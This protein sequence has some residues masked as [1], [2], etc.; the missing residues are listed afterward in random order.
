MGDWL[1]VNA[2]GRP[3]RNP[4]IQTST[5]AYFYYASLLGKIAEI[6]DRNEDSKKYNLLAKKIK[7]AFNE[8]FLNEEGRY[9]E[10]SQTV[11]IMPFYLGLAPEEKQELILKRLL[12]YIEQRQG[13]LSS[14][15]V[16]Y[17][18]LFNG[19]THF[20]YSDVAYEMATKEEFPG[21][22]FL[23]KN[24]STTLWESWRGIAYNFGSLGGIVSWYI[25]VLAGIN[26]SEKFPG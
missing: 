12:E 5:T 22:G 25:K 14:G 16:G 15:F 23:L 26:S 7:T 9:A 24:G 19:L 4:I 10:D 21:W 6:L 3:I 2:P 1:E 8:R 18:Y 20:G 11:Q 17:L 13:H